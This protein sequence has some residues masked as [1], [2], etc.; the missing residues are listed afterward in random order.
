VEYDLPAMRR[1]AVLEDVDSLPGSKNRPAIEDRDR[2]L[3]IGERGPNVRGH[4]V[5]AF[6]G[7][8]V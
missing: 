1:G 3:R 7:V 2:K 5:W 8:T 6:H 4:I